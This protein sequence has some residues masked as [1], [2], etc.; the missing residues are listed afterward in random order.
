VKRVIL[1]YGDKIVMEET[2]DQALN[3]IFNLN[4]AGNGTQVTPPA[5]APSAGNQTPSTVDTNV[6][7]LIKRANDEFN[8]AKEAQQKGDWTNYGLHLNELQNI[9]NQLNQSIK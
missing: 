1:G 9:L 7:N 4:P 3:A 2:L 5:V 8:A 6:Q